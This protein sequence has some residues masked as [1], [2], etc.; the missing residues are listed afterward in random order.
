MNSNIELCVG[1]YKKTGVLCAKYKCDVDEVSLIIVPHARLLEKSEALK[2]LALDMHMVGVYLGVDYI[3][4]IGSLG[5]EY[6]DLSESQENDLVIRNF[7][8]SLDSLCSL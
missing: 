2:E 5:P 1:F 8:L 7:E 6:S 3:G 4:K